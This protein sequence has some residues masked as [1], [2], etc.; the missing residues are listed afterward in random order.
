MGQGFNNYAGLPEG[1]E[2]G[3]LAG[4]TPRPGGIRC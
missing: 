4:H 1:K 3:V 2:K